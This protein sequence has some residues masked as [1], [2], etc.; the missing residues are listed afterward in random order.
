[1]LVRR[2]TAVNVQERKVRI[3]RKEE[4]GRVTRGAAVRKFSTQAIV[5]RK[6]GEDGDC[7]DSE[8]ILMI[9]M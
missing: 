9:S 1:M 8:I 7:P 3:R 4:P 6:A 5:L 2:K